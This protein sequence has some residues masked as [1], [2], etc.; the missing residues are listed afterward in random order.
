[1]NTLALAICFAC[2]VLGLGY[3]DWLAAFG[4]LCALAGWSLYLD[5]HRN[6]TSREDGQ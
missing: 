6:V 5:L 1:M 3:E 4:W 2:A